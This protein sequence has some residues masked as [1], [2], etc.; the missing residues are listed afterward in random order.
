MI[1][2]GKSRE[3]QPPRGSGLKGEAPPSKTLDEAVSA[4]PGHV[5]HS[6]DVRGAPGARSQQGSKVKKEMSEQFRFKKT[7]RGEVGEVEEL[8][9]DV[10]MEKIRVPS[11]G[12]THHQEAPQE[13]DEQEGGP[14]GRTRG[15]TST[16]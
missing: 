7:V 11:R 4:L 14:R 10:D 8:D 5:Q 1:F 16:R 2:L 13:D 3:V 12:A 6:E 15:E 9:L